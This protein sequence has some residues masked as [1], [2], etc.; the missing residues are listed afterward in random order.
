[1]KKKTDVFWED[2]SHGKNIFLKAAFIGFCLQKNDPSRADHLIK[3]L[4]LVPVRKVAL[5]FYVLVGWFLCVGEAPGIRGWGRSF[6]DAM[7][8]PLPAC[9]GKRP[10][11]VDQRKRL[12]VRTVRTLT[13]FIIQ[14]SG[15]YGT[16]GGRRAAI[17]LGWGWTMTRAGATSW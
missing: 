9:Q 7:R 12:A 15:R 13:A 5:A 14:S 17:T 6:A 2:K 11:R 1:M 16:G 3:A 8:M 10:G 4:L